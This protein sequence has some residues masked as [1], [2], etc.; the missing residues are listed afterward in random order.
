[1]ELHNARARGRKKRRL[2]QN[3]RKEQKEIEEALGG[4]LLAIG[5]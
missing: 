2:K 4:I 1:L 3:G 5:L